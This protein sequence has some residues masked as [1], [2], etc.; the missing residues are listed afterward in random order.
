MNS[1]GQN[2]TQKSTLYWVL[3][4]RLQNPGGW[5]PSPTSHELMN[6]GLRED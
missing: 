1:G 4:A 5:W 3:T 2:S 6:V